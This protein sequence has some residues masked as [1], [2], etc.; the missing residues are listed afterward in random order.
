MLYYIVRPL[1]AVALQVFL[2]KITISHAERIP[3]NKPVILASNHPTAFM[4]P[5]ILAC[6]L[7]RPLYFLVRGD[8]F[9]KSFYIRLLRALHMLPVYRL[10]DRGYK[11]VKAN[12]ETFDACYDALHACKTIMI[13]AEGNTVAEKRLRPLKKGTARL[14]FGTIDKYPDIEEVYVVPVGVN[15]TYMDRF[16]AEVM[17]DFGEPISVRSYYAQYYANNNEGIDTFTADLARRMK[18]SLVGI[19]RKEDEALTEH[20]LLMVR[21]ARPANLLPVLGRDPALLHEEMSIAD[22]VNAMPEAEKAARAMECKAYFDA[23]QKAGVDDRAVLENKLPAVVETAG[24][25]LGA[26]LFLAGYLLNFIPS[27]IAR[28]IADTR[29]RSV[30]FYAPVMLAVALVLFL[31]YYIV[32]AILSIRMWGPYG[33]AAT[34]LMAAAGYFAVLYRDAFSTWRNRMRWRRLSRVDRERVQELR[35]PP[36]AQGSPPA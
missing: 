33:L 23:L 4:E 20:L 27:R 26:S 5:C 14:A 19:D 7:D 8:I 1:A 35:T 24:I 13:L 6:F 30:E 12:F 22:A 36:P 15:F 16:R 31:V 2:R 21:S 9:V 34:A 3:R 32:L 11:F 25:L 29:V 28:H 18:A 17:V 10:K